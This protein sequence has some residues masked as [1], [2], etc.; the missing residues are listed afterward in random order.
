MSSPADIRQRKGGSFALHPS[1]KFRFETETPIHNGG[2]IGGNC[3]VTI[4]IVPL[5]LV[6]YESRLVELSPKNQ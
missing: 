3:P 5:Q 6:I 1:E 2:N 4:W